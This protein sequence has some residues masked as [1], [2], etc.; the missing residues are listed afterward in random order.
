MSATLITIAALIFTALGIA[1]AAF[2]WGR[3]VGE[4]DG[5]SQGFRDG[6]SSTF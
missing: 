1:V 4:A 5:Y 3:E 2:S 6:Q